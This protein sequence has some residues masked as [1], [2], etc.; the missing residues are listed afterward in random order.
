MLVGATSLTLTSAVGFPTSGTYRILVCANSNGIISNAEIMTATG[1]VG[2]TIVVARATETYAGAQTALAHA[3]GEFVT[4]VLT[5]GSLLGLQMSG[6]T[7]ATGATGVGAVGA[8]GPTG[9]TGVG[10]VG[11][12]GPTGPTGVGSIGA[13]GPT[14]PTGVGAVGSTGATGPSGAAGGI[15]ATGPTGIGQTGA[16]GIQGD[17]GATGPTG[18]GAVGA[19]GPTGPTG[20][21]SVGATGPTGVVGATGPTGVGAMGPTGPTGVTGG[22]GATGPTGVGATGPTGPTGATGATA[23][24]LFTHQADA[25]N[26]GTAETDLYTDTIA[27]GQLASNGNQISA[28]YAGIYAGSATA[29]ATIKFYFGGTALLTTGALAIVSASTWTITAAVVR[30]STSVVRYTVQLSSPALSTQVYEA[31]GELT[32]LDLTVGQI[33]K[34]T[35]QMSGT[36]AGSNQITAK[37]GIIEFGQNASAGSVGPIGP[38]GPTG[39]AGVTSAY[40]GYNTIGGTEESATLNRLYA[41]LVTPGA[42]YVLQSIELYA[43]ENA[44][45]LQQLI[46]ALYEDNAGVLGKVLAANYSPQLAFTN[47]ATFGGGSASV[48]RWFGLPLTAKLTSG[49]SYWLGWMWA[50]GGS[51]VPRQFY[52]GSGTDRRYDSG[53]TFI[54]DGGRYTE[55]TDSRKYS[56]R[57]LTIS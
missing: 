34:V 39:P 43:R 31:V 15:G 30:V 45:S 2:T 37:L 57:A 22:V 1:A 11:A 48:A 26:S 17:V 19:T 21:G 42:N 53:G 52:N 40:L 3:D 55:T 56:V 49:T 9:P 33:V 51:A 23:G 18:A 29:S 41:Q 35:G 8:T 12:T 14:G 7:G 54:V 5:E 50:G 47:N 36:G 6:P 13:T 28:T 10:S 24:A 25:N 32:G 46:V 27:G 4:I 44:D 16:T 20:V 38:T